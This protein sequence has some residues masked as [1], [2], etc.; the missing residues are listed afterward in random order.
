M[1][2]GKKLAVQISCVK[3][4]PVYGPADLS[5]HILHVVNHLLLASVMTVLLTP[6]SSWAGN[7]ADGKANRAGD[8]AD[9][10][11][12]V[13]LDPGHGGSN[14]GARGSAVLEKT[15]TLS[16][17]QLVAEELRQ[18]RV[19]VSLTRQADQTLT[20]RQR[21][22]LAN[23]L[24]ADLFVS[25][26]GNASVARTQRG[27]ETY[28]LT[29]AAVEV[30][31]PA[32]RGDSPAPRAGI[33][34]DIASVLDDIE[35][36]ATQ[37]EAADLAVAVQRQLRGVRG[38]SGD[39][40]VRQDAQHVLLGATMPAVL[41]EVGFVDHPVEGRELALP[42]TQRALAHAIATAI[43]SQLQVAAPATAAR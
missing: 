5:G 14:D 13:V 30:I 21:S 35:R 32:L 25:L 42:E 29:P 2:K 11:P 8:Q 19:Q 15:L 33:S 37:W 17:A 1:D 10:A 34:P 22:D 40:G 6:A 12:H 27:F 16:M 39:R 38:A 20:L 4:L 7:E 9:R 36:G 31:A 23:R 43:L 41:V 18:A 28:V 24:G 3:S 26:H